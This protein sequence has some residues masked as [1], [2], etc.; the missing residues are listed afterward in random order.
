MKL[1]FSLIAFHFF[2]IT[3]FCQTKISGKVTDFDNLPL[4]GANIFIKDSYDGI[5]S[6]EDGSFSFTTEE[7]GKAILVV[8]FVGYKTEEENV[9]LDG[10]DINIEIL[11][12]EETKELSSV[13]IS[14]GSF[15]ASDERK[16][17][18]LRP[19]DVVTT[20]SDA[21]IYSALETLPGT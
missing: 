17:V 8:S 12:E 4:P 2:S 14:S 20:G 5:L 3:I 21:D 1:I 19:L 10:E 18:I 9:F 15:E 7:E 11:L 6:A 16:G 13:V